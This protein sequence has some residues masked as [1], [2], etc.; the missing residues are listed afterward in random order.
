MMI[1]MHE[2]LL[3]V[4]QAG[5]V[6]DKHILCVLRGV[7]SEA[8]GGNGSYI[9][10]NGGYTFFAGTYMW[11]EAWYSTGIQPWKDQGRT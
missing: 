3:S 2:T 10:G 9:T 4:I 11:F 1:I 6:P 8:N 7:D 5:Y